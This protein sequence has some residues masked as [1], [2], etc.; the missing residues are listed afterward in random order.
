MDETRKKTYSAK[1]IL[2]GIGMSI[3]GFLFYFLVMLI[4]ILIVS[5]LL[6]LLLMIP[7][8][9]NILNFVLSVRKDSILTLA[10]TVGVSVASFATMVLLGLVIKKAPTRKISLILLGSYIAVISVIFLIV[11][12]IHG[13]SFYANILQIISA[14]ILLW[15]GADTDPNKD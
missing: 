3:V 12:I 6:N 14:G 9:G 4:L 13:D 7:I 15:S 8:I 10:Q 2:A 11:N 5:L 1:N